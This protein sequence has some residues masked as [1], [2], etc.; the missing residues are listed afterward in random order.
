MPADIPPPNDAQLVGDLLR[1]GLD[2]AYQPI[3]DLADERVI[4]WEALLRGRL[5][6]HGKVNPEHVVGSATRIGALDR[7]MRQVAEQAV[8]TAS[9]ASLLEGRRFT[10]SINVEPGQ[11]RP[12]SAFLRW[13]VARSAG[14]PADVVVEVTERDDVSG[15]GEGQA[16]ALEG[17]RQGGV[18]LAIDDLGAGGSRAQLLTDYDWAWV[19]LDRSLLEPGHRREIV[20]RHLVGMLHELGARVVAE[21]IETAGQ[22]D[23]V[24][25][26]G[27]DLAQGHLLGEPMPVDAVLQSLPGLS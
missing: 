7:V 1:Q 4:G 8:T 18:R 5:R 27:A 11:V 13:L 15:W 24:R 22:L 10:V 23:L 16:R 6:E 12:D 14:G 26:V 3:I 17:L 21:G 2:V 9:V 20:L 25:R 19:K